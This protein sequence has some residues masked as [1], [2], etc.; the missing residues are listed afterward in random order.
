MVVTG[1]R[2][3]RSNLKFSILSK[4][5]M[6]FARNSMR[7]TSGFIIRVKHGSSVKTIV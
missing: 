1:F 4:T 2:K 3:M 7:Y 5:G 6:H